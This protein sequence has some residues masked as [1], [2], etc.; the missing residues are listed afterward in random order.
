MSVAARSTFSIES[1]PYP[2][3]SPRPYA[4]LDEAQAFRDLLCR[5]QRQTGRIGQKGISERRQPSQAS[6]Q[7]NARIPFVIQPRPGSCSA[8][9]RSGRQPVSQACRPR[10][11]GTPTGTATPDHLQ[12]AAAAI[13]QKSRYVSVVES[14]VDSGITSDQKKNSND[15]WSEWQDSNLRPL[16][17]ER[18]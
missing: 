17:P 11:C 14:M 5:V 4:P 1:R 9:C 16:R 12:G 2:A 6:R 15:F 3:A 13:Q 10:S 18:K 7:G 8:A